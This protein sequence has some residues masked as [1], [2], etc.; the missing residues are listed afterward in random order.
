VQPSYRFI[1]VNSDCQA[2]TQVTSL[3]RNTGIMHNFK[4]KNALWQF[5]SYSLALVQVVMHLERGREALQVQVQVQ[6]YSS[7]SA[8]PLVTDENSP[9]PGATGRRQRDDALTLGPRKKA[10]VVDPILVLVPLV[11]LDFCLV[12][13]QTR[14][15][16]MAATLAG[17]YMR[18]VTF[19]QYS[20]MVSYV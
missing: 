20:P 12:L 8:M 2:P 10:Y 13:L 3:R 9:P 19:K 14:W 1:T 15:Y 16:H 4:F 18:C 17:R 5:S 11:P 6:V 7:P